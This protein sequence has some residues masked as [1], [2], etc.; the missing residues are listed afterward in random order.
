MKTSLA[1]LMENTQ[2]WAPVLE[3]TE[4]RFVKLP[5]TY[6]NKGQWM[7]PPDPTDGLTED[8]LWEARLNANYQAL[9]ERK[10]GRVA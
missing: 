9:Q 2:R 5:A 7:E 10:H 8:E 4:R 1:L 6:L 3:K